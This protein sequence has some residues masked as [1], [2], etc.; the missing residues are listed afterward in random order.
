MCEVVAQ[1]HEVLLPWARY[2][3]GLAEPPWV[4]TFDHHTDTLPAF[5]RA[6][7]EPGARARRLDRVDWRSDDSIREAIAELRH[8]EHLDL[9]VCCGIAARSI[10]VAHFDASEGNHP[11][12]RV[13]CDRS[14]PELQRLL[15]DPVMF[16]PLARRVFEAD[17]LTERLRGAGF[18]PEEHPG[19][20]FD[21]DLDYLLTFEALEPAD[22][23]VFDELLR[24]AGLI[25]VSLESEWV[26]LLRVDSGVE[27]G[28]LLGRFRE[29]V[30]K[31]RS[32]KI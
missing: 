11:A 4:L 31:V 27:A 20:V 6:Y 5:G 28:A 12:I 13:E 26:R 24:R 18:V 10:V 9:A 2:R 1:H 3:R 15:N 14:W 7:P 25:T 23:G 17:F 16:R 21:L 22:A 32:G 19:F 30:R 8:D 29:R